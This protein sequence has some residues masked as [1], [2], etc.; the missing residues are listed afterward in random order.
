MAVQPKHLAQSL[1]RQNFQVTCSY[2]LLRLGWQG[3]T[4]HD[5]IVVYQMGKVGSTSVWDSLTSLEDEA[6]IYHIHS[7]EPETVKKQLDVARQRFSSFRAINYDV[8]QAVY[9]RSQLNQHKVTKPWQVVTLVRDPIARGLSGFF[10]SLESER[11]KGIDYRREAKQTSYETVLNQMVERFHAIHVENRD[12]PHPFDWFNHELKANLGVDI[13]A[14]PRLGESGYRIYSGTKANVLL[15]KLESLNECYQAA[16]HEFLGV[17]TLKLKPS[18]VS[19]KKRYGSFY[20]DFLAIIDLPAHYIDRI[21]DSDY[22]R[23]F[24]TDAE[25]AAFRQQWQ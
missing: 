21:Y 20:K 1:L 13:F 7:L 10:Q 18:N 14:G 5:K 9:L 23:Q 16:C 25:I 19:L 11:H 2:H 24:Y 12:R 17:D 15:F 8:I 22:V 3:L 4:H 6:A